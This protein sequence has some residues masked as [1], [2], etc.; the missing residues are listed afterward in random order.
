MNA[1]F[2]FNTT[3]QDLPYILF[4]DYGDQVVPTHWH[5][6]IEIVFTLEGKARLLVNDKMYELAEDEAILIN[7][8]DTH[9][10]FASEGHKR[11]VI[12][13]DVDIIEGTDKSIQLKNDLLKH[14]SENEKT[15]KRWSE[16]DKRDLKRII[17]RLETLNNQN[18]FGRELLIR[19]LV[20]ELFYLFSKD[21]H[22]HDALDNESQI[23][24]K[25][26]IKLQSVFNY[27]ENNYM[28]SITLSEISDIAG[29]DTSYFSR[30]FK[31]YTN[32]TFCDYL[33][34]YRIGKAQYL[35]VKR[36]ELSISEVAELVGFFSIKTFNRSFL[37]VV[38]I[39]PTKFRKVNK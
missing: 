23:N 26:M 36:P 24:N 29:F 17:K 25:A 22:R 31:T 13:V 18:F 15:S 39:P 2:L 38:K 30:F 20:F 14:L 37:K 9:F 11:L 6:E 28:N 1:P 4:S 16:E 10:Y 7:G 19:A 12:I 34:N 27:I 21:E 35:L 5:K 33:T 3:E 32:V 8:G